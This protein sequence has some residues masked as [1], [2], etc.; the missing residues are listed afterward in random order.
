MEY[1][2]AIIKSELKGV[3]GACTVKSDGVSDR[4]VLLVGK[5]NG[6]YLILKVLYQFSP[7]FEVTFP[8][9]IKFSQGKHKDR[10]VSSALCP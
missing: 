5:G 7:C 8:I 3:F 1:H 4:E 9:I 2:A 6:F 10:N